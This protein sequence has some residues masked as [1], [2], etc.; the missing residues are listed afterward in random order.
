EYCRRSSRKMLPG[1]ASDRART[2]TSP[3]AV[4]WY[5]LGPSWVP[6]A[7]GVSAP[8]EGRVASPPASLVQPPRTDEASRDV[9]LAHPGGPQGPGVGPARPPLISCSKI[10]A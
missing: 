3:R 6:T 5:Q 1:I 9:A 8:W 4:D 2:S 7:L 10:R